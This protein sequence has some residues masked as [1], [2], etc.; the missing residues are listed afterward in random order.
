[1]VEV[2]DADGIRDDKSYVRINWSCV[3]AISVERADEFH[4]HLGAA[5]RYAK[6]QMARQQRKE[7]KTK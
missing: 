6:R 3:G 4:D 5:L 1:M 2:I 7:A